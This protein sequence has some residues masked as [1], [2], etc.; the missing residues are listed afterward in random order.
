[1]YIFFL[2]IGEVVF[3]SSNTGMSLPSITSS[4]ILKP[5][6]SFADKEDNLII[7]ELKKK[8]LVLTKQEN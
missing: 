1:M 3:T 4:I 5:F 8:E 6:F 2:I 7:E